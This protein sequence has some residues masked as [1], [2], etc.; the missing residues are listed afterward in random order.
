MP[1]GER[2]HRF[3]YLFLITCLIASF[4]YAMNQYFY[5][6]TFVNSSIHRWSKSKYGNFIITAQALIKKE[7]LILTSFSLAAVIAGVLF[8][9]IMQQTY[10]ISNNILQ[11]EQEKYD[12]LTEKRKKTGNPT[13][14]MNF[15]DKGFIQNWK[16]FLFPPKVPL[17]EPMM[18]RIKKKE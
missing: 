11:I 15:Y 13:P 17:H 10:L 6:C 1:V 18:Y 4:Y 2:T 9:F 8:F 7:Q 5:L 14:V 3:F 16:E 12:D